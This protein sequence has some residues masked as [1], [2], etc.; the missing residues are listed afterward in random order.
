[1][2]PLGG[3]YVRNSNMAVYRGFDPL[4]VKTELKEL[5]DLVKKQDKRIKELEERLS[6]LENSDDEDEEN[7]T[8]EHV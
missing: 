7:K 4:K 8:A 6:T 1:M 5:K 2:P 3:K